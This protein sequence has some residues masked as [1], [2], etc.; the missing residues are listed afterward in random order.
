[1][2]RIRHG[3]LKPRVEIRLVW[4]SERSVTRRTIGSA[5]G[6][7]VLTRV[8]SDRK[9]QNERGLIRFAQSLKRSG[10]ANEGAATRYSSGA[11]NPTGPVC[12]G[13][14]TPS[15]AARCA[16]PVY[17][18]RCRPLCAPVDVAVA[19]AVAVIV[20]VSFGDGLGARRQAVGADVADRDGS[21]P[22][23]VGGEYT[24]VASSSQ[25]T[26]LM[27]VGSTSCRAVMA[28]LPRAWAAQTVRMAVVAV[29]G[30]SNGADGAAHI[31][32]DAVGLVAGGHAHCPTARGRALPVQ[33]RPLVRRTQPQC[34]AGESRRAPVRGR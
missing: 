20:A 1:M 10:S 30:Q 29:P 33:H 31:R 15:K 9:L 13:T 6:I 14:W 34:H 23:P 32:A 28:M 24:L 8:R 27:P 4:S 19:V 3:A 21:D 11:R 25:R 18:R 12:H 26:G 7:A 22:R 16:P 5:T 2:L 17:A